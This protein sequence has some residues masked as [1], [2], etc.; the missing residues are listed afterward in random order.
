MLLSHVGPLQTDLVGA[1]QAVPI[2]SSPRG[3][4]PGTAPS[5]ERPGRTASTR[6]RFGSIDHSIFIGVYRPTPPL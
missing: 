4:E 2:T 1:R 5:D 6:P 3:G